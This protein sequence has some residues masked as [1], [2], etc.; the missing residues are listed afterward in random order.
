MK[1][2]HRVTTR[3]KDGEIIEQS[4]SRADIVDL[5]LIK[6]NREIMLALCFLATD[7]KL[8]NTYDSIEMDELTG[9]INA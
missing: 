5:E 2:Y 7:I 4:F 1:S 6:N 3:N 8:V 9:K